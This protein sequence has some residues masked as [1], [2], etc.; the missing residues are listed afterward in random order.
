MQKILK[1]HTV[2]L[3]ENVSQTDGQTDG[4]Q[5]DGQMNR[6]DFIGPLMQSWRFSHVFR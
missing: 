5:T 3:E 2:D 6:T 1:I 4:Q